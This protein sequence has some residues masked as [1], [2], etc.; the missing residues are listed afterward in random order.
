MPDPTKD[1]SRV[2]PLGKQMGQAMA[3]LADRMCEQLAADGEPDDRC[4]S[5]AFRLGTVPNGCIQ[6][7]SDVLKAVS[8]DVPFLCHQGK[9][10]QRSI[11]HGWFA[12]RVL[13]GRLEDATGKGLPPCPWEFSPP[14]DEPGKSPDTPHHEGCSIHSHTETTTQEKP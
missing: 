6:T 1:H 2:T 7:Q 11:C 14:D 12:M 5:C 10:G 4:K 13:V 8:E 3:K 9:P